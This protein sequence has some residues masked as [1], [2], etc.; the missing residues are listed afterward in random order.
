MKKLPK[1]RPI[2]R[3]LLRFEVDNGERLSTKARLVKHGARLDDHFVFC[4]MVETRD[5][6]FFG[7]YFTLQAW[8]SATSQLK[9]NIPT[10][11]PLVLD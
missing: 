11:W 3:S 6:L 10:E 1:L 9:P 7:F 5:H 8:Q 2:F 4:G